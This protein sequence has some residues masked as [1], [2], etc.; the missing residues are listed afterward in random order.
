MWQLVILFLPLVLVYWWYYFYHA[1]YGILKRIGVP[2]PHPVIPFFG[3][4]LVVL[5]LGYVKVL[6]KW[7]SENGKVFGYYAGTAV[8]MVVADLDM[9]KEVTVKKFDHFMAMLKES[10]MQCPKYVKIITLDLVCFSN[11][12]MIGSVSG[13]MMPLIEKSCQTLNTV[14]EEISNK[15]QSFNILKLYNKFTLE[16]MLAVA[17]GSEVHLLK[18]E[19]SLLAEAAAGL[20]NDIDESVFV[21]EEIL[22]SHFPL[23]SKFL[24]AMASK[25]LPLSNHMKYINETSL[26]I[27]KSREG[28]LENSRE[29]F[30]DFLQLLMDARA[31]DDEND[32]ESSSESRNK[33]TSDQIVGLCFDFMAAGYE[34]T[35]STLAYTTYLLALNPDEQERLCEAIDNYYQENEDASLYDASQNIPYLD[36]VIQEALRMYPP[37]P[38]TIRVCKETCTI[39][40]VTFLKGCNVILPIQ[41][42]HYSPEYWDQPYAF[43]PSRFS[44]E[45]KEGRNPLSHIPFGWGPRSCIGMRFA[46]MEAKA[47]LVSILRKYRFE[48]SPDTQVPLKFKLGILHL[49]V[50]GIFIK[51]KNK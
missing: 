44:P 29:K 20:F 28:Q 24:N 35:A 15:G 50:N 17:F 1:P 2:H 51:V 21:G 18:G 42:L 32:S 48:R 27:I 31:P 43:K 45:G 11:W 3:N 7:I 25:I 23:L 41:Y 10:L 13:A 14:M 49:P 16:V 34:T 40:G 46:L 9:I 36:W 8:N 30:N 47:C 33:L 26:Q 39:N 38:I 37:S 5:K 22:N 12:M 4:G 19:G 6:E